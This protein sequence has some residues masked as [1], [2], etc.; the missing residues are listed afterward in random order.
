[1]DVRLLRR[2]ATAAV[3]LGRGPWIGK[4]GMC[5][6]QFGWKDVNEVL[7]ELSAVEVRE[8]LEAIVWRKVQEEWGSWRC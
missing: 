3:R 6:G 2:I 7:K 8:M 4:V 1:M 5:W